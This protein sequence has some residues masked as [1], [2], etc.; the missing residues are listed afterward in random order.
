MVANVRATARGESG[1][2]VYRCSWVGFE[3]APDHDF[4]FTEDALIDHWGVDPLRLKED[5]IG[6]NTPL[7]IPDM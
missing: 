4:W 3:D 2:V 6:T 1:R 5:A 7:V